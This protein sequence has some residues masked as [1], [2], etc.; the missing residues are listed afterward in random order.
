MNEG[1][2]ENVNHITVCL[3]VIFWSI[4][5]IAECLCE[6]RISPSKCYIIINYLGSYHIFK[7]TRTQNQHQHQFQ[8]IKTGI[9]KKYKPRLGKG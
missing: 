8:R 1:F 9:S 6:W 7:Q 5:H 3:C 4:K 2:L